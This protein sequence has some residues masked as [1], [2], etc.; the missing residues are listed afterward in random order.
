M[1]LQ[2]FYSLKAILFSV[3]CT[4]NLPDANIMFSY[5]MTL[6]KASDIP[7]NRVVIHLVSKILL[8]HSKTVRDMQ[9]NSLKY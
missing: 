5:V 6:L 1:V 2:F 8:Q 4:F 7:K 3:T 9:V